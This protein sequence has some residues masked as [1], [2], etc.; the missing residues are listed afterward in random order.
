MREIAPR[1]FIIHAVSVY[2]FLDFNAPVVIPALGTGEELVFE[3]TAVAMRVLA[4]LDSAG[5]SRLPCRSQSVLFCVA[6]AEVKL[7]FV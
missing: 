6:Y 7:N 2:K 4:P 1:N 5:G 3:A